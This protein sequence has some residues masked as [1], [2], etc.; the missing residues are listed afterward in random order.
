MSTTDQLI[1]M[2]IMQYNDAK[3][4]IMMLTIMLVHQL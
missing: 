1:M 4:A 2:L 3:R